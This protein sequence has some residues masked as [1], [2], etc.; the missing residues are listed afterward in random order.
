MITEH[1]N[2]RGPQGAWEPV[3]VWTP[4]RIHK[5]WYWFKNIFRRDRNKYVMP[6]QGYEY[7][8]AFDVLRDS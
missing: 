8:T 6:H 2:F 5:K 1:I 4:V 3:F 7:G